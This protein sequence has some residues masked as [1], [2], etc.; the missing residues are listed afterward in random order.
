M[1]RPVDSQAAVAQL[2]IYRKL[3]EIAPPKRWANLAGEVVKGG[4]AG[5]VEDP[6]VCLGKALAGPF[7]QFP[8][9][10]ACWHIDILE[11]EVTTRNFR[12]K[13]EAAH[14][15]GD[16]VHQWDRYPSQELQDVGRKRHFRAGFSIVASWK[17][18]DMTEEEARKAGFIGMNISVDDPSRRVFAVVGFKST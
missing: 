14:L 12:G 7:P 13:E 17:E 3:R 6:E 2:E 5:E 10:V 1:F 4:R 11:S 8:D 15:D 9:N 18:I 16:P